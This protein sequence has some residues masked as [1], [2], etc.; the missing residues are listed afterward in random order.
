MNRP[1]P[2]IGQIMT[3]YGQPARIFR[4]YSFG[5]VDVEIISTGK[6]FRV[7]GLSFS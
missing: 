1:R 7:T 6:C 5:T 3:V 4:V 2:T